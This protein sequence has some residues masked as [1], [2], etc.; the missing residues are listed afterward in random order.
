M[1]G[2]EG[3]RA[4]HEAPQSRSGASRACSTDLPLLLEKAQEKGSEKGSLHVTFPLQHLE[5][6]LCR[7]P[8]FF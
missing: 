2:G 8:R 5:S 3:R 6:R 4:G 7:K 1:G